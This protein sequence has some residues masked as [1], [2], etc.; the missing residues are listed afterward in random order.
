MRVSR[1]RVRKEVA[2][3]LLVKEIEKLNLRG[4]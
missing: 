1:V 2:E 3:V 4:D